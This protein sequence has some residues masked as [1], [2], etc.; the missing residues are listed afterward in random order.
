M[1]PGSQFNHDISNWDVSAVTSSAELFQQDLC[2]WNIGP[3]ATFLKA[4]NGSGCPRTD[5]PV[6]LQLEKG[7]PPVWN[8]L[9]FDGGKSGEASVP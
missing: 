2:S 3:A 5:D 7:R 1:F 6:F 4:F 9:C 8:S